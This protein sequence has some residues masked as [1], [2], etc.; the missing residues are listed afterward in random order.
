MDSAAVQGLVG[1]DVSHTGQKL[2][3]QE[4]RFDFPTPGPHPG[5]EFGRGN[6]QGLGAQPGE[7]NPFSFFSSLPEDP[8]KPAGIDE[9]E[10]V[11]MVQ[12]GKDQVGM[13]FAG[14]A[15]GKDPQSAAHPQV[16]EHGTPP[17]QTEDYILS[18]TLHSQDLLFSQQIGQ[19]SFAALQAF[20]LADLH[21]G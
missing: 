5:H 11:P 7:G 10:L 6:F 12:E 8:P 9:P 3:V 16:N 13:F 4:K 17:A 18:P 21:P 2:L 20:L 15:P 1:I 19:C 14:N